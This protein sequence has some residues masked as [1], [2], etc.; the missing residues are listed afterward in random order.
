MNK[1][2]AIFAILALS[3]QV[4]ACSG[5]KG[6]FESI[7]AAEAK[8]KLGK[9]KVLILDIRTPAEYTGPLGNI[10][11]SVLLPLQIL[12]KD[13]AKLEKYKDY[14]V[15]VYCRSG[16]RSQAGTRIMLKH[17]FNAVNMLGGIRAWNKLK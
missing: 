15:I 9:E 8:E 5:Q 4:Y 11:G 6:G 3:F 10:K 12:E 1:L 2:L 7:T 14:E 17:G 16:N 13:I